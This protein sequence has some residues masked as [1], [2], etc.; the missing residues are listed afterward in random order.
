MAIPFGVGRM[1]WLPDSEKSLMVCL[2]ISIKYQRVTDRQTDISRQ[3]TPRYAQYR[4]VKL[5]QLKKTGKQLLLST[6]QRNT[7]N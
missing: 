7:V 3:H 4:V 6:Q 2:A 1:V 5:N